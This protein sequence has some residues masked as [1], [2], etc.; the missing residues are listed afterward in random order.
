MR[1]RARKERPGASGQCGWGLCFLF[2]TL[3]CWRC[4]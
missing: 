4:C 1:P 2:F 3:F